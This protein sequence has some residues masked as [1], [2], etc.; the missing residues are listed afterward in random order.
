MADTYE[1]M[2]SVN[3]F[4]ELLET[5]K[6]VRVDYRAT[7]FRSDYDLKIVPQGATVYVDLPGVDEDEIQVEIDG[8][9]LVISGSRDFDHDNE[10]AEEFVHIGRGYGQFRI[11]IELPQDIRPEQIQARYKRGV[12]KVRIPRKQSA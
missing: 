4:A 1:K 2:H 11:R 8:N 12:L 5:A 9:N 10:D 6:T 7:P 3:G